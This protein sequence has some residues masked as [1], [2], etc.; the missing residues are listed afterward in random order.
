MEIG[1]KVV[2]P[3]NGAG[4]I[5]AVEKRDFYG[6]EMIYCTLEIVSKEMVVEFPLNTA[7]DRRVRPVATTEEILSEM[8][9]PKDR[10]YLN[11]SNW[12]KRF[13][14]TQDKMKIGTPEE[15]TE[16][17]VNLKFHDIEKG[18]SSGERQLYHQAMDILTSEIM[19]IE[20]ISYDEAYS[21]IEDTLEEVT[22]C[23]TP[24]E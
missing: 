22:F 10:E 4:T 13:Q 5:V 19:L 18:L 8:R 24:S 9:K 17:I 1:S 15:M 11:T 16:V 20:D 23:E 14:A 21:I 7:E 6:K 2:Y 12:N 3:L